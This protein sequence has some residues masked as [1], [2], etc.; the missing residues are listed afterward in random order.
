MSQCRI[1]LHQVGVF[2]LAGLCRHCGWVLGSKNEAGWE[3]DSMWHVALLKIPA[4]SKNLAT[5]D[6]EYLDCSARITNL[7]SKKAEE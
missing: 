7:A 3:N 2:H 6:L 4:P 1:L 5:F